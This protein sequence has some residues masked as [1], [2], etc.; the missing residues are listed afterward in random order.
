MAENVETPAVET[1]TEAVPDLQKTQ[2]ELEA[3][4]A[5][6]KKLKEIFDKT[7]SEVAEYKR[8]EKERMSDEEKKA[9]EIE[10][11]K[12]DYK[13]V[14]LDLNKTKAE[15]IFAKKG[16]AETEYKGVIEAL[17]SNVPPEKMSEVASEITKLVD[18][19]E[20]KTAEL[21]KTSLTKDMDSTIKKDTGNT[22]SD[23]KAFQEQRKPTFDKKVKF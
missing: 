9:A 20:A 22:V 15:S 3:A 7:A 14:T 6:E 12:N 1:Q 10:A 16:W 23:F 2:A 13:A 21:T 5:R 8:K 4:L 18:A 17:A 19:R 11:L